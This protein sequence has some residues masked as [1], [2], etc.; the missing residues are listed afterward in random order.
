MNMSKWVPFL[1]VAGGAALVAVL[2]IFQ[3]RSF[4]ATTGTTDGAQIFRDV[5]AQCHGF[6]GEGRINLTP[7]LRARDLSVNQIKKVIQ[8]GGQKMPPMPFIQG[9]AL[10]NVARYVSGL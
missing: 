2:L 3:G 8:E 9:E 10:E 4:H 6:K 5:C 7:P 1:L